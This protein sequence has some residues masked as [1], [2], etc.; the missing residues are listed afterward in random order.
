MQGREGAAPPDGR[1]AL[2]AA[3]LCSTGPRWLRSGLPP[4]SYTTDGQTMTPGAHTN[5]ERHEVRRPL[6]RAAATLAARGAVRLDEW[7]PRTAAGMTTTTT[8]TT[9]A[10]VAA[11]ATAA[12]LTHRPTMPTMPPR[13]RRVRAPTKAT[14]CGATAS[15]AAGAPRLSCTSASRFA[16][17][18]SAQLLVSGVGSP[19]LRAPP[20]PRGAVPCGGQRAV[21]RVQDGAHRWRAMDVR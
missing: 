21:R 9:A 17:L 7:R 13:A 20:P 5:R 15:S 12:P 8:A 19:T 14:L 4:A 16:T 10:R 1:P 3:S 18:G 2:M 11:R 6:A